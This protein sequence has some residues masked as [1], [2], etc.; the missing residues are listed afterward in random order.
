MRRGGRWGRPTR[1]G[2]SAAVSGRPSRSSPAPSRS[3]QPGGVTSPTSNR[4][5]ATAAM[6]AE[7][8]WAKATPEAGRPQHVIG[9]EQRE[10]QDHADDRCRDRRKRRR[11]AEPPVRRFDEG[12]AGEDEDERGQEGEERDDVGR[13]RAPA[14]SA[15]G[16]STCLIQP[17][18]NPTNATTMISGPGVV[19]PSARPSIICA[20]R[21]PVIL[22][23]RALVDV[24]QHRVGA[25][26][27]QQRG[28][29]E[30]PGHLRERAVRALR[31]RRAPPSEAPRA[32]GPAT[33]TVAR[34]AREK[35][36]CCG[37]G[38]SSSIRAGPYAVVRRVVA[39]AEHEMLRAHAVPPK[40]ADQAG[41][42]D[43][44]AGT[45]ASKAKIATNAATAMAH[46]QRILQRPRA[47]AVCGMQHERGD[48]RLDAVEDRR[49]PTG[50]RR[51]AM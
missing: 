40:C 24:G 41:S 20:R 46:S 29:G 19:S 7:T 43:D 32:P 1:P 21:Q 31:Q 15:S 8:T 17:P 11:E 42:E 48:R 35:R 26:E 51:S 30:E 13:Q 33:R 5:S 45:A 16:P 27:G 3:L 23:D 44:R 28:L 2:E 10:I 6:I 39:A 38:V 37:V 36:A 14:K 47:D 12:A 4:S 34:C 9:E 25:A 50:R 49:R 18:T 22:V